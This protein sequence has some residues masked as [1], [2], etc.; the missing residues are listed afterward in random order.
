[1]LNEP[2]S[3]VWLGSR[4]HQETET[5][6]RGAAHVATIVMF[7]GES[8]HN[9]IRDRVALDAKLF[10]ARGHDVMVIDLSNLQSLRVPRQIDLFIGYQGWGRDIKLGDGSLLVERFGCPYAVMLGDHPIQHAAR[11]EE[12][13]GNTVLFVASREHRTFL[14]D[15][16]QVPFDIRLFTSTVSA[17]VPL[18]AV[19]RDLPVLMVGQAMAPDD[20]LAP[21]LDGTGL[22]H[23]GNL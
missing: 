21:G 17:S 3:T 22:F 4:S 2:L 1:M 15:V 12:L 9:V 18:P 11:I 6:W 8:A 23:E 20:F 10:E 14:K 19:E 5:S 13:P 7:N 16:L